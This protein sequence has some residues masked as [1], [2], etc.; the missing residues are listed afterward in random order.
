MKSRKTR[1]EVK[2]LGQRFHIPYDILMEYADKE[3]AYCTTC[4]KF[5]PLSEFAAISKTDRR[6]RCYCKH[7]NKTAW[8]SRKKETV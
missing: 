4:R 6:P 2:G 3:V 5:K 1:V 8:P 7:C